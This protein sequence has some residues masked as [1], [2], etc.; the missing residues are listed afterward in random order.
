M[1][2]SASNIIKASKEN[3]WNAI[4]DIEGATQRISCIKK[5]EILNKPTE[6]LIG[7]KWKETR[8]MF[9]KESTET[10]WITEAT[11]FKNY[12]T[13]AENCGCIYKSY[14]KMEEVEGGIELSMSFESIPKT[15][16]AKIMS[17]LM[18]LMGG[19]IKK[20]FL[21]DINEIKK[22]LEK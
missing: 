21:K 8:L 7:L 9:G 17:P 20:A 13:Q 3:V 15:I 10:M 19:M 16:T 6:G 1:P 14:V 5:I 12:N 11:E 4:T 2:I 18:F 22:S